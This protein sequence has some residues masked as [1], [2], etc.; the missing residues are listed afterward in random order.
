MSSN[1]TFAAFFK[2]IPDSVNYP[3][4]PNWTTVENQIKTTLGQAISGNPQQIL[5]A[6]QQ[7]ATSGG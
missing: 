2:N 4:D 3:S 5:N 1:P 7:T 6:I